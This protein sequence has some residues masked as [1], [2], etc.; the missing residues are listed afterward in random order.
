MYKAEPDYTLIG[1]RI[2]RRRR[3]LG[4]TQESLG[5]AVGISDS[6]ISAIERGRKSPSL[7]TVLLLCREL[8]ITVDYLLCGTIRTDIDSEIA[9][10]IKLC[11]LENKKRISKIADVFVQEE[12]LKV[13]S[14]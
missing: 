13:Q 12:M 11:S 1:E 10:K 8:G 5:A 2:R 9:D 6:H 3:E 7:E 4:I 14:V